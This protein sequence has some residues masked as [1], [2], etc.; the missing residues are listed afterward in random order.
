MRRTI[1]SFLSWLRCLPRRV[2]PHNLSKTGNTV[3]QQRL[4]FANESLTP[5]HTYPRALDSAGYTNTN[6]PVY[7]RYVYTTTM[8]PEATASCPGLRDEE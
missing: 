8:L 1:S 4:Q 2:V 7:S 6:I 3:F 5:E